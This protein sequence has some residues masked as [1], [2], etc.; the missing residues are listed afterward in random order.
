MGFG[1]LFI[2]YFLILNITYFT[3]SDAISAL[4]MALGLYKLAT[5]NRYFKGGFYISLFFAAIGLFEI[6]EFIYEIFAP[7]FDGSVL[8]SYVAMPRNVVLAIL[9]CFILLGIEDVAKEVG[10]PELA[11]KAKLS[12]IPV[13]AVYA[14]AAILEIP[15]LDVMIDIKILAVMSVICLG[16]MFI[17]TAVNLTIIYS[18]YMKICMPNE[19]D[20]EMK[21]SKFG[22]V[23]KYREHT[24]ERQR[25]Y[26]EYKIEKIKKKNSKKKRK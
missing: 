9:T 18:A 26:A 24:A 16:A 7:G 13:F 5:V 22:F 8:L 19:K 3:V 20:L 11:R 21:P 10:L 17:I 25:E 14:L 6:G 15:G 4:I 12:I 2:G 1:T 23:N